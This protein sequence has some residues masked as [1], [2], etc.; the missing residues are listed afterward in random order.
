[1]GSSTGM[2][3]SNPHAS[4]SAEIALGVRS[5]RAIAL[6]RRAQRGVELSDHDRAEL[7][8][9]RDA[10]AR[11]AGAVLRE[12]TAARIHGRRNIASV[13]LALTTAI[14]DGPSADRS[15]AAKT[16]RHLVD[17]LQTV[18]DGEALERPNRLMSFLSALVDAANRSTGRGVETLV[19]AES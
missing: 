8:V 1:M 4:R 16:L 9:V 10:L 7:V 5:A 6:V 12:P 3:A 19:T 17:D 14:R 11:A 18:I 15:A 2:V 13:G